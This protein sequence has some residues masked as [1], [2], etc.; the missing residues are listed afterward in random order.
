ME[1][2]MTYIIGALTGLAF[3]A[4][5]GFLKYLLLWRPL[6]MDK[7][8]LTAG[9][10]TTAQAISMAVS[11]AVLL[12]IFF[13]R[14]LWPYSFEATLIAAAVALSL[15]GRLSPL[16]DAKKI[17]KLIQNTDQEEKTEKSDNYRK[18]E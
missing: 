17:E 16:R 8:A 11:V 15:M 4:L 9:R 5:I 13:L 14:H 10:L 12:V 7:R 1:Q 6:V 3:G 2:A 18:L